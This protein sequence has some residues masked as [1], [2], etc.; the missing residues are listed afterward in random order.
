MQRGNK[1]IRSMY[2]QGERVASLASLVLYRGRQIP[3]CCFVHGAHKVRAC[4]EANSVSRYF[5]VFSVP[6]LQF[7]QLDTALA[8][9]S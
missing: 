1:A 7:S 2:W 4:R 9:F 3:L 6:Q 8:S 5:P